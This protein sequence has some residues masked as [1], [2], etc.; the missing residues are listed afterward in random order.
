MNSVNDNFLSQ[1]Y[2]Y[3]DD[4]KYPHAI[5]YPLDDAEGEQSLDWIYE[6]AGSEDFEEALPFAK[7]SPLSKKIEPDPIENVTLQ[8]FA[9]LH[10]I[11]DRKVREEIEKVV[12]PIANEPL[13][14]KKQSHSYSS[15]YYL[16][17]SNFLDQDFGFPVHTPN[18]IQNMIDS[19]T[20]LFLGWRASDDKNQKSIHKLKEMFEDDQNSWNY[21]K[22]DY[23]KEYRSKMD[24]IFKT[25]GKLITER[26][27][28]ANRAYV[29]RVSFYAGLI[30]TAV[31]YCL[32]RTLT[33]ATGL[34][35][36]LSAFGFMIKHYVD[37]SFRQMQHESE[38]K[39]A[40]ESI[41]YEAGKHRLIFE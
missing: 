11:A 34:A 22:D 24:N 4:E 33:T 9:H 21:I 6:G 36:S 35:C 29:Y 26:M 3:N 8:I 39:T 27:Q 31:G 10:E 7:I 37:F 17:D 25:A 12:D 14:P 41:Y 13:S 23:S 5:G 40:V 38:L 20:E 2:F 18:V 32:S 19:F 15:H 30:I 28:D 1:S 16:S